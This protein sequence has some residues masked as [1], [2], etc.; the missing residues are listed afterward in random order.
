MF[1][2][3]LRAIDSFQTAID[4]PTNTTMTQF[5][6]ENVAFHMLETS[7]SSFVNMTFQ[8]N[9]E[10]Y[11]SISNNGITIDYR[12]NVSLFNSSL[13]VPENVLEGRTG[14][15]IDE[16]I[17]VS[18]AVF[19]RDIL[20][21]E[22]PGSVYGS[23]IAAN[24]L[25]VGS[26]IVSASLSSDNQIINITDLVTPIVIKFRKPEVTEIHKQTLCIYLRIHASYFIYTS[27]FLYRVFC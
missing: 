2:S 14:A 26:I 25:T 21:Q 8:V 24:N 23:R 4:L 12:H 3:I 9:L 10:D 20:F 5:V 15:T 1:F 16:P 11:D 17:R 27:F 22:S 13:S 7:S 6:T 19:L 18:Y